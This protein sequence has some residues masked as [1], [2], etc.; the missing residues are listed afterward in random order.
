MEEGG[1]A[2]D[3][4]EVRLVGGDQVPVRDVAGR[5]Q[6]VGSKAGQLLWKG[7]GC[8]GERTEEHDEQGRQQAASA[9]QPEARQADAAG[10]LP[11]V[12]EQ[13]GD[14]VAAD[15]EEDLD[16]EKPA[17]NRVP[18]EMEGDDGG[19]RESPDTVEPAK[20]RER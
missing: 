15:D 4:L 2:P 7:D 12:H 9:T 14:E 13:S 5:G 8:D 6:G 18:A 16:A 10:L 20:A 3:R 17:G 11:L 1:G 19:D